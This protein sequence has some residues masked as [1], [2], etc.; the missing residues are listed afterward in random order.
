MNS[1]IFDYCNITNACVQL[2]NQRYPEK[3][4]QLD[5]NENYCATAYK[6]LSDYLNHVL[7]KILFYYFI[8]ISEFYPLLTFDVSK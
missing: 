3:D 5:I 7:H 6:M 8:R 1:A 2:N 4:L